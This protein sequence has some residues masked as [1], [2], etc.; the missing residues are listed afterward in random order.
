MQYTPNV[1]ARAMVT[2]TTRTLGLLTYEIAQEIYGRQVDQ[3][4]REAEQHE[5][6]I[7]IT[8]SNRREGPRPLVRQARQIEQLL[9]RGSTDC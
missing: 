7:L 6:Q 9:S 2:R 4:L 8:M 5:Y 3:I 1:M